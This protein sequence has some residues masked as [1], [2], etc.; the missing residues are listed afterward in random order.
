M[1]PVGSMMYAF[2]AARYEPE[3]ARAQRSLA[4]WSARRDK[5]LER[6]VTP[7]KAAKLSEEFYAQET[8]RS[9]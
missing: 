4:I 2:L 1:S 9:A 8:N 7:E 6:G 5:L 3:A